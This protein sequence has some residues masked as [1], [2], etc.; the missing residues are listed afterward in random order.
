ML[1]LFAFLYFLCEYYNKGSFSDIKTT[2][3]NRVTS[4]LDHFLLSCA[5]QSGVGFS[6]I[7][8]LNNLAKFLVFIQQFIV[9]TSTLISIYLFIY[10]SN[11]D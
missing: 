5:I 8:P 6:N 11:I 2:S 1:I 7:I 4:I 10:F 3:P 9:L